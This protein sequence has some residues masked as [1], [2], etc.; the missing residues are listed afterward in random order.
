[1]FI[2]AQAVVFESVTGFK[3]MEVLLALNFAPLANNI[4]GKL[5]KLHTL[6]YYH[7]IQA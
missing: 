6:L 5:V 2:G 7:T 3:G 4:V 1:M